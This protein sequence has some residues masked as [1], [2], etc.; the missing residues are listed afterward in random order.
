MRVWIIK[1]ETLFILFGAS[2]CRLL[3]VTLWFEL[4]DRHGLLLKSVL[5]CTVISIKILYVLLFVVTSNLIV[6]MTFVGW[7]ACLFRFGFKIL[8][9]FIFILWVVFLPVELV[10]LRQYRIANIA[11][12]CYFLCLVIEWLLFY[13]VF[14]FCFKFLELSFWLLCRLNVSLL[15]AFLG[16]LDVN[17]HFRWYLVWKVK[18]KLILKLQSLNLLLKIVQ[19]VETLRKRNVSVK[20]MGQAETYLL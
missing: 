14:N 8:F 3:E 9:N 12:R 4:P 15:L 6:S 16:T 10:W 7:H 1:V 11:V 20:G 13:W 2:V 17:L 5:A 18:F 19:E